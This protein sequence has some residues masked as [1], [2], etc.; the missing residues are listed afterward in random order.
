MKEALAREAKF[1][2][3]FREL[4]EIS[5][6]EAAAKAG[7][8]SKVV[9]HLKKAGKWTFDVATNIGTDVAEEV[10]KKSIGL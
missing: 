4:A 3:Q 6:A 7:K 10:I 5:N 1:S 9:E 2:D 8:G